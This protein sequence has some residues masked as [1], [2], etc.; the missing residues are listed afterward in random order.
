[1]MDRRSSAQSQLS[2]MRSSDIFP[3]STDETLDAASHIALA[4]TVAMSSWLRFKGGFFKGWTM[5]YFVLSRTNQLTAY[6]TDDYQGKPWKFRVQAMMVQTT[7]SIHLGFIVTTLKDGVLTLAAANSADYK[8]WIEVLS[9][10]QPIQTPLTRYSLTARDRDFEREESD[11]LTTI[12]RSQSLD[13][14]DKMQKEV[15]LYVP[16]TVIPLHG[17]RIA[18]AKEEIVVLQ[19]HMG[20]IVPHRGNLEDTNIQWRIGRPEYALLDLAFLQGKTHNHAPP[21]LEWTVQNLI[22]KWE[23]EVSHKANI[24]QWT[25][26]NPETFKVVNMGPSTSVHDLQ[27]SGKY[28][29]ML[30]HCPRH[31]YDAMGS[32]RERSYL[33]FSSVFPDGFAWEVLE[34]FTPLPRV[35]FSW[36]HWGYCSS[37]KKSE[38]SEEGELI[39]LKGFAIIDLDVSMRLNGMEFFFKVEPFL[40]ALRKYNFSELPPMPTRGRRMSAPAT[41]MDIPSSRSRRFSR[42]QRSMS[43]SLDESVLGVEEFLRC[44]HITTV[45]ESQANMKDNQHRHTMAG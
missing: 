30:S 2:S 9:E 16:T 43:T 33:S 35:S 28:N 17:D 23:M 40:E 41:A 10:K 26:M 14:N 27:Q 1:M 7:R 5:Y 22:K 36:R 4:S 6:V 3:G 21:S 31:I 42:S 15:F 29:A 44:P 13:L 12:E 38:N 20:Q 32:S 25:T 19:S 11:R 18:Q 24:N 39:E 8:Q 37:K 34:V 45:P